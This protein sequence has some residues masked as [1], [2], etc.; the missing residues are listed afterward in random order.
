[1]VYVMNYHKKHGIE[2]LPS[3]IPVKNDII[4]VRHKYLFLL[5]QC[6]KLIATQK[7]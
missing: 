1:M 3:T 6:W 7:K 4:Y 2:P 5:R